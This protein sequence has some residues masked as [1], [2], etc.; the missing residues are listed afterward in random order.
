MPFVGNRTIFANFNL[1]GLQDP[2]SYY[3]NYTKNQFNVLNNVSEPFNLRVDKSHAPYYL[4]F[5]TNG[6]DGIGFRDNT[7]G[8]NKF[9]FQ[10][11]KIYFTVRVKSIFDTPIKY[12]PKLV[13]GA[14]NNQLSL[15]ATSNGEYVDTYYYNNANII[16]DGA[17]G[18]FKGYI[19][20]DKPYDNMK[21]LG[22]VKTTIENSNEF[23]TNA[24]NGVVSGDSTIFNIYPVEGKNIYRKINEDNDQ[25]ENYKQLIFQNILTDKN[26][27]FDKFLGT[28]V[29][30]ISGNPNNLGTKIYE[31]V[32][33]MPSNIAD[34]NYSNVRSLISMLESTDIDVEKYFINIPPSLQRVVDNLS[35]PA[36]LQI[37]S[38]NNFNQNFDSKGYENS[39]IYGTNKGAELDFNTSELKTGPESKPIIGFEKFSETYTLLD[40]NLLST[41]DFRYNKIN[42]NTYSLSDYDR[43]WGWNLL[44]PADIFDNKHPIAFELNTV[45]NQGVSLSSSKFK[46]QDNIWRLLDQKFDNIKGNPNNIKNFYK[47]YEYKDAI[48]GSYDQKFIDYSNPATQFET[49]TSYSQFDDDGG[50]IDQFVMQNIYT[51]LSLIS[52]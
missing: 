34:V 20:L 36:S 19:I 49:I 9:Y 21:L 40:T 7:F 32:S 30:D 47:F 8:L 37:G 18:Y 33:N 26:N 46:L 39:E 2:E 10:H 51:G 11:Q 45:D 14:G 41:N 4:S 17:G 23:E 35:V 29:G 5:T 1:K 43:S 50:L 52:S 28:M 12:L 42:S 6:V 25:K 44:V 31:K 16:V 22:E 24:G 13:I 15:S 38:I 27:F 48:D 3:Y